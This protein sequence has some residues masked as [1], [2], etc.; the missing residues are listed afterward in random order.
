MH[1]SFPFIWKISLGKFVRK[2]LII[3]VKSHPKAEVAST[4]LE[5]W[6]KIEGLLER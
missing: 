2:N 3:D 6:D 1:R 5:F 4:I